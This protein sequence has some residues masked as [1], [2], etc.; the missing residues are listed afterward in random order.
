MTSS[1]SFTQQ[2]STLSWWR[3]EPRLTVLVLLGLESVSTNLDLT[4][5]DLCIIA[6]TG[7]GQWEPSLQCPVIRLV[8][9][10]TLE[11]GLTRVETQRKILQEIKNP[12]GDV[13]VSLS[14]ETVS[15][16]L[17]PSPG[18]SNKLEKVD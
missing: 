14:D 5:A 13:S 3:L 6:E 11:D 18:Y 8:C 10:G 7:P 9:E 1:D 17:N 2:S 16:I 15:D 12:A 4:C